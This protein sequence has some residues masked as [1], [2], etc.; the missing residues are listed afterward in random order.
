MTARSFLG[1]YRPTWSDFQR[2]RTLREMERV[3]LQ[4]ISTLKAAA[5]EKNGITTDVEAERWCLE[6]LRRELSELERLL[7]LL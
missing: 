5:P 7:A 3:I 2:L 4:R 6:S 1:P